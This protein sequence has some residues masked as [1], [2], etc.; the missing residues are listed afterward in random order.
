MQDPSIDTLYREIGRVIYQ[1]RGNQRNP[2]MSQKALA[3]AVGISRASIANIERGH[4]R[5][6]LH[7]LYDIATVLDV[8]PHDLMPHLDRQDRATHLPEDI[9]KEL[10]PRERAAVD[11]LLRPSQRGEVKDEKS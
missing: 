4:H 11:R 6:Q 5:V 1:L 7:V 10:N 3:E 8:E 9:K 2:K